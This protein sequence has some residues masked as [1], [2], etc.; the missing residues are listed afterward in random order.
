MLHFINKEPSE[1]VFIALMYV[2]YVKW[3][4]IRFSKSLSLI[5]SIVFAKK[6]NGFDEQKVYLHTSHDGLIEF[7]ENTGSLR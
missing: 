5:A 1:A 4:L 2:N 6:F 3:W 7:S